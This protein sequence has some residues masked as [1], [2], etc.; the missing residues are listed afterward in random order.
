MLMDLPDLHEITKD[1]HVIGAAHDLYVYV[2]MHA[3]AYMCMWTY[4]S[5]RN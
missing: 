2:C 3:C 5:E 4:A 1:C